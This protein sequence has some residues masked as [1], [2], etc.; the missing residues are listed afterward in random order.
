MSA[1]IMYQKGKTRSANPRACQTP[2]KCIAEILLIRNNVA[3]GSADEKEK[4]A[5]IYKV[6]FSGP[7]GRRGV[8]VTLHFEMP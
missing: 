3:A 7:G 4:T 6:K 1:R 8:T 5:M 2:R